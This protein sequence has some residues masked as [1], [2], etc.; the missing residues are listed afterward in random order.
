M[1]LPEFPDLPDETNQYKTVVADPPWPYND[2]LPGGGRGA[3]SHYDSLPVG[4]IEGLGP[5]VNKIAASHA[6]LYMWSTNK[7]IDDAYQ[8]CR[9]WGFEPK[10]LVTWVKVQDEP[11]GLP[12]DR[13]GASPVKERIGMGHYFRNTTEHLIF[14]QKGSLGTD[15]N[16]MPS[17]FFAERTEHS[18]KPDKSYG[19]VEEMSPGPYFEMFARRQRDGWD[20]WGDES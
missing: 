9:S 13:D 1:K 6:H 12:G 20:V 10:T 3:A 16:D 8:V 18:R 5:F 19:L 2:A 14:A 15:R 17:H 4:M 7:F 11:E